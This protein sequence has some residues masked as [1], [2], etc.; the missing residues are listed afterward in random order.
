M[1][2]I[3]IA[4]YTPYLKD[5]DD[6]ILKKYLVNE[7]ANVE[8][9]SWDNKQYNWLSR[10][11]VIIRSTWDYHERLDEY[12]QW[13]EYLKSK[14]VKVYNNV[15]IVL[16]N[17]YKNKQIEWLKKNNIK[18]M[19]CEIFSKEQKEG[20]HKP[21]KNIVETI[22]KYFPDKV[23]KSLFVLKPTVSARS[24]NTYL[25]DPFNINNDPLAHIAKNCDKVF[26]ELLNKFTDRGIILQE[27]GKGIKDGEYGMV[28]LNGVLVQTVVKKPGKI[29]GQKEKEAINDVPE[30]LEIFAKKIVSK[31]DS[32][33][34]LIARVDAI[35]ENEEPTLMELE[36]A[37][38]NIYIRATDK[39]GLNIYDPNWY[40]PKVEEVGCKNQKLIDF[41]KN[42]IERSKQ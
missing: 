19:P 37:E 11:L 18:I 39:V 28:F 32:N 35:L 17:I 41:A 27:F 3:T 12:V 15:D 24:N 4:S 31:L 40:L 7:G 42:I 20:M 29:Y 14:K 26:N 38:P 30:K 33:K 13:L 5:V 34:V 1:E 8:I 22:K 16:N 2:K 25:I 36:L 6:A 21:E 10:D 9:V 23:N